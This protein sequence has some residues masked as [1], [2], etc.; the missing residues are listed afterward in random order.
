MTLV[1]QKIKIILGMALCLVGIAG[2]LVPVIPGV[3]MV[4]AGVA[5]IGA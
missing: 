2:T 3:P 4:L 5:L 1:M